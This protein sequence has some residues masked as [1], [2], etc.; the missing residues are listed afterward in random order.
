MFKAY[1]IFNI[2]FNILLRN[3]NRHLYMIN[4]AFSSYCCHSLGHTTSNEYSK[5][6]VLLEVSE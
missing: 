4:E 3:L 5:G 2:I 1:T 6:R